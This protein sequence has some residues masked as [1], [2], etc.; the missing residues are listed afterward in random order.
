[1]PNEVIWQFVGEREVKNLW[2]I[3][4]NNTRG[5]L[6][7][8]TTTIINQADWD[9][10][11]FKSAAYI[12]FF[13]IYTKAFSKSIYIKV[14]EDPILLEVPFPAALINQGIYHRE[15]RFKRASRYAPQTPDINFALWLLKIES[16]L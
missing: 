11:K 3:C 8:I 10:W 1:V 13:D 12:Q 4:Q 5:T 7:R 2:Y 6:F 14:S 15:I 16:D 9:L